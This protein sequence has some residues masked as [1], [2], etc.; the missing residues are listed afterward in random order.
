MFVCV[1]KAACWRP[2]ES[3]QGSGNRKKTYSHVLLWTV[4]AVSFCYWVTMMNTPCY[5]GNVGY[6][7]LHECTGN[8][9][10]P[11]GL[12]AIVQKFC[13]S[14]FASLLYQFTFST[15]ILEYE[16]TMLHP[17]CIMN[18]LRLFVHKLFAKNIGKFN[19]NEIEKLLVMYREIEILAANFNGF[20]AGVLIVSYVVDCSTAFITSLYTVLG[21][22]KTMPFIVLIQCGVLVFDVSA[23]VKD[24][25]GGYKSGV[26]AVSKQVLGKVKSDERLMTRKVFRKKIKSWRTLRIYLGSSN[27]FD[28]LT[29][30]ALMDLNVSTTVS[31]LL[32]QA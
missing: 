17:Y 24:F 27:Y 29:P 22:Y 5:P 26:F 8:P 6:F 12:L 20:H 2:K 14:T 15:V 10:L 3:F 25:D 7:L 31:L 19:A 13:M 9:L 18:Y 21:L 16:I 11:T 1:S 23:A 28:E 30:L 32:L 4:P